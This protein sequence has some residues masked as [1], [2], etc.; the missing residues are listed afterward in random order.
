MT[1]IWFTADLH[2]GHRKVAEIRGFGDNTDAHNTALATNWDNLVR[3]GDQVWVL[4]DISIGH[5]GPETRALEWVSARPGIKHLIAGNH[6]GCHPMH[7]RAHKTHRRFLDVFET[8]QSAATLKIV[9][10]RV[11]LSHFPYRDD[12]DGD[13]TEVLRHN[14][15]RPV[16]VGQWL[17]HGHTHSSIAR[18]GRQLH[19]GVDAHD[20]TP[21]PLRWVEDQISRPHDKP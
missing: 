1:N 7:S 3:P 15:W 16:D 18:R 13:H 6:D 10:Q 5:G 14:E 2:L 21:V 9:G 8:V 17:L 12:P 11:L 4:G 19:V 20:L